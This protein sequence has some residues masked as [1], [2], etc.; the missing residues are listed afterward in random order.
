[1][2]RVYAEVAGLHRRYLF[3]LPFLTPAITSL[4]VGTVTPIPSGLARPLVESLEC[5]A[6]M[7]NSDIDTIIDPPP[8]GL[9]PY[10]QA[11][12]LALNRSTPGSPR[13]S[14]DSSRS[15]P[16]ES[17]PSDPD[18]AGQIVH[19]DV[20]TISTTAAPQRVWKAVQQ[21]AGDQAGWSVVESEPGSTLRLQSRM[22]ARGT[23]WLEMTVTPQDG[24]STY[25]QRACFAPA[26]VRGGR[27]AGG[28]CTGI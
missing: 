19:T 27:R 9:I 26:G 7:R 5:D 28:G 24:G 4:W 10:R 20:R 25:T 18:W 21:T 14:W 23:G 1:M 13:A 2:M 17:L 22:R 15:E 16:A 8:D 12:S 3:V 6:V 11:V